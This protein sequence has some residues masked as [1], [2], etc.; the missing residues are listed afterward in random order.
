[1][2]QTTTITTNTLKNYNHAVDFLPWNV[3]DHIYQTSVQPVWLSQSKH[4]LYK[5]KMKSGSFFYLVDLEQKKKSPAFNH[6]LLAKKLQEIIP[7]LSSSEQESQNKPNIDAAN[8]P[9]HILNIEEESMVFIFL[10]TQTQ[11]T[12]DLHSYEIKTQS[13]EQKFIPPAISGNELPS[14]DGKTVIF[15]KHHNIYG[16]SLEAD[17]EF[18]ITKDGK[19]FNAYGMRPEYSTHV[20]FDREHPD[21]ITPLAKW[22]PNS[23]YVITERL[24]QQAVKSLYLLQHCPKDDF[25]PKL[26][27]YRYPMPG[28]EGVG[29][30][31]P[32]ILNMETHTA[33][34]IECDPFPNPIMSALELNRVWWS[35]DSKWVYMIFHTDRQKQ[36][37]RF[38]RVNPQNGATEII[39]EEKAETYFDIRLILDMKLPNVRVMEKSQE[40]IW[41]SERDGYAQLFLYDLETKKLKNT[42]TPAPILVHEIVKLD[43]ETRILY[44][45]GSGNSKNDDPYFRDLMKVKLNGENL[46]CLTP[47]IADHDIVLSPDQTFFVDNLSTVDSIPRS[48][49]RDLDGNL[50]FDIDEADFTDLYAM[51]WKHPKRIKVKDRAGENELYGIMMFPSYFDPAESYPIIDFMY[52]GPQVYIT[53]KRIPNAENVAEGIMF[54]KNQA[55]AELGFVVIILDGLGTSFRSKKFHDFSFQNLEDAGGLADHVAGFKQLHELFPFLNIHNVGALGHS[56][57]GFMATRSLLTYSEFFKVAI[58]SAGNHDQRGYIWSWAEQYQGKFSAEKY[59]KQ[60]NIDLVDNLQGKLLLLHGEMDDNVH[61]AHTYQLINALIEANKDFDMIIFPNKNHGSVQFSRYY[62]RKIWDYFV[63]HLKAQTPPLGFE[64]P[65]YPEYFQALLNP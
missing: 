14:P 11:Y 35:E 32:Y 19:E 9:V 42:I 60:A 57:G 23:K 65:A 10:P 47:E 21:K 29:M 59:R 15:C 1:M 30:I 64:I 4:F 58:S 27:E 36:N 6:E 51:G 2:P 44:F 3:I 24:D 7:N 45:I 53:P 20:I 34:P 50:L 22:S 26:H 41:Y 48:T 61:P 63:Q 49:V 62:M 17:K 39:F 46:Q 12:L 18:S 38:L 40:F 52:P 31:Y 55:L 37:V 43:E 28:D 56:G 54:W 13:K 33:T 8:L 25:R 5:R 16:R